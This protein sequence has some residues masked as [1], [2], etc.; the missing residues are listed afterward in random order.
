MLLFVIDFMNLAKFQF[1]RRIMF[2]LFISVVF[3]NQNFL[4]KSQ[5]VKRIMCRD[6]N[7]I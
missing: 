1:V 2:I 3:M 6:G 4:T 7:G 5:F